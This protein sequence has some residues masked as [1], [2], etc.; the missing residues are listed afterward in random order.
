ML[1]IIFVLD[2]LPAI[3]VHIQYL[4]KNKTSV[5]IVNQQKNTF[6]YSGK[7]RSIEASFSDIAGLYHYASFGSGTGY[8]SWAEYR[9]FRIVFKNNEEL[10]ISCLMVND[11][12]NKLE[13]IFKLKAT[14]RMRFICFLPPIGKYYRGTDD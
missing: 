8:Y 14:K 11:I 6:S 2:T 4:I 7:H 9:F 13:A 10:V 12:K 1:L 3:I 5:L